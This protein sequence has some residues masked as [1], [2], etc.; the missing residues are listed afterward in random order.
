M[1][2]PE[3]RP[4]VRNCSPLAGARAQLELWQES[5]RI[6][7]LPWSGNKDEIYERVRER[8]ALSKVMPEL[9]D[10]TLPQLKEIC[11]LYHLN[12]FSTL[13][14]DDLITHIQR[15]VGKPVQGDEN[16]KENR[17]VHSAASSSAAFWTTEPRQCLP[18]PPPA[19]PPT[20]KPDAEGKFL[21]GINFAV[22]ALARI[23]CIRPDCFSSFCTCWTAQVDEMKM[24]CD[25]FRLPVGGNKTQLVTRLKPVVSAEMAA[26]LVE[27]EEADLKVRP[28]SLE[29]PSSPLGTLTTSD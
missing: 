2:A 1:R 12:G 9:K 17:S 13:K 7:G 20:S 8:T 23:R 28:P 16:T 4:L 26:L 19:A 25:F 10:H 18:A 3:S 5:C 21:H 29:R 11:R 24:L 15:G 6:F 27:H 14:K 22:R